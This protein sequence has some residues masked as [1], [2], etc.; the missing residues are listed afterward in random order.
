[1]LDGGKTFKKIG[2]NGRHVDDHALWI[3][4]CNQTHLLIGGDGG[5]YETFD[6]CCLKVVPAS[7]ILDDKHALNA[8]EEENGK[9]RE[10]NI[11]LS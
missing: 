10:Y 8:I 2:L 3:D 6:G 11:S 4:P 7:I 9:V 1:M 5:I